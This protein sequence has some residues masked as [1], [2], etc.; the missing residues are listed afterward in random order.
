[1][2]LSRRAFMERAGGVALGAAL[3]QLPF[4]L[5]ARGLLPVARAQSANLVEDTFNALLAFTSP[6]NDE[7]SRHQGDATQRDGGV[8]SGASRVLI[9]NLDR[10]VHASVLG[11]FGESVPASSG[12][13]ALLNHYAAQANPLAT[14]PFPSHFARLSMAEKA[15]VF[16]RW[17]A[18]PSWGESSMRAV[19]GVLIGYSTFLSWSEAGVY[20]PARR[21]PARRPVG[22]ENSGYDGPA[23]GRPELKGYYKGR[24]KV[25]R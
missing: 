2:G 19:V 4:A 16:R 10:Y 5:D 24:R 15:D 1:V 21:V 17:E 8:A 14:G 20:D 12:V 11:A 23:E 9:A 25:R 22:W 13:A 6:G 7:Y 3:A 18:D